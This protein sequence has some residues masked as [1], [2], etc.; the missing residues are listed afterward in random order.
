MAPKPTPKIPLDDI[1]REVMKAL[2]KK[3]PKPYR[4]PPLPKNPTPSP[5]GPS[6]RIGVDGAPKR[7]TTEAEN[8]AKARRASPDNNYPGGTGSATRE[9]FDWSS[10]ESRDDFNKEILRDI[11]GAKAK[12][13]KDA[14]KAPRRRGNSKNYWD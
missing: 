6:G 13:A 1:I 11:L 8:A 14:A 10:L 7:F 2:R 12:A 4:R 5:P 3:A 9:K